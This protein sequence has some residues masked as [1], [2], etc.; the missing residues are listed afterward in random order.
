MKV[1]LLDTEQGSASVADLIAA[2]KVDRY[3]CGTFE[4]FENVYWA[5]RQGR[6]KADVVVVDT[7]DSLVDG[8]VRDCTFDPKDIDPAAGKTVWVQRNKM[9]QNQDI[10][11]RVNYGCTYLLSGIRELPL[12]SIFLIHE[13]ERIDPTAEGLT[14]GP[15][16]EKRNM[17]ALPPK[18]YLNVAAG[19]DVMLRMFRT[20]APIYRNGVTYPKDTRLIQIENTADAVTGVRLTPEQDEAL[21]DYIVLPD[22]VCGLQL[23]AQALGGL[24]RKLTV[25]SFPKVGKTVFGCTLP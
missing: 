1:A 5:L 8:F 15:D 14:S 12:P 19:S 23:L 21:P 13:K 17:P 3:D 24:P 4:K 10:W 16:A 2:G 7:V 25:Y 22:R 9:R 18:I 11:N 6:I 20:T